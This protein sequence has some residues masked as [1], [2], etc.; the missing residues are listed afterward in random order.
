LR[1]FANENLANPGLA[2]IDIASKVSSRELKEKFALDSIAYNKVSVALRLAPDPFEEARKMIQFVD[3]LSAIANENQENSVQAVSKIKAAVDASDLSSDV[4][5][6]L[7]ESF[8]R[9]DVVLAGFSPAHILREYFQY[10]D[11]LKN[12][13]AGFRSSDDLRIASWEPFQIMGGETGLVMLAL[14][15]EQVRTEFMRFYDRYITER[16]NRTKYLRTKNL[17]KSLEEEFAQYPLLNNILRDLLIQV[18]NGS[19][20]V[21]RNKQI[22]DNFDY[23]VVAIQSVLYQTGIIGKNTPGTASSA[24]EQPFLYEAF[25]ARTDE[26]LAARIKEI[27]CNQW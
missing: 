24:V 23:T 22:L 10:T 1:D 26:E 3:G 19:G 14:P 9:L 7:S 15:E 4:K 16:V 27:L 13:I 12:T 2:L 20:R 25:N 17:Q 8:D 18:I 11:F 21:E 6:V 5:R